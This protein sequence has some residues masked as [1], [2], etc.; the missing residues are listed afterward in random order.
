MASIPAS[1]FPSGGFGQPKAGGLS[2]HLFGVK[3]AEKAT[4]Q[5]LLAFPAAMAAGLEEVGLFGEKE[6]K[7]RTPVDYGVLRATVGHFD[8]AGIKPGGEQASS[9]D[10]VFEVEPGV[11]GWSVTWG[12]NVE[13]APWVEHGFTMATRRLVYIDGVG[14]RWVDPFSYRGAHMFEL[15]LEATAKAAPAIL[16]HWAAKALSGLMA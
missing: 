15:G 7:E 10:A 8:P 6:T 14:F 9:G 11:D 1:G 12:T 5:A 13:Y 2:V 4:S 16:E 3:E